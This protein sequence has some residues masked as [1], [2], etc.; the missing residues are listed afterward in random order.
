[1]N[2]SSVNPSRPSPKAWP[3][4][5]K[6]SAV[7]S[8]GCRRAWYKAGYTRLDI[9]ATAI[10]S[11]RASLAQQF[12]SARHHQTE[13]QLSAPTP[14]LRCVKRTRGAQ[15]GLQSMEDT[16]SHFANSTAPPLTRSDLARPIMRP[17]Q[18]TGVLALT[19]TI[20]AA[21]G[22]SEFSNATFTSTSSSGPSTITA[23]TDWT[24]PQLYDVVHYAISLTRTA[25]GPSP[26]EA[27]SRSIPSGDRA[28]RDGVSV[29]LQ[30][31]LSLVDGP[32]RPIPRLGHRAVLDHHHHVHTGVWRYYL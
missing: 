20:A 13:H 22:V 18:A 5:C 6:L 16:F 29:Q 27:S 8:C 25:G 15:Y 30:C 24:P 3:R 21:L 4:A 10:E 9:A 11:A 1:M 17:F 7:L 12:F 32:R 28:R 31:A 26:A 14:S 23:A 2:S 19:V